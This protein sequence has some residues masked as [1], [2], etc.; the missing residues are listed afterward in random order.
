MKRIIIESPY[1]GDV[2]ANTSYARKCLRDALA[3]DEAPLASHLLYTQVLND[4]VPAERNLGLNAAMEWRDMAEQTVFYTDLGWSP[5]MLSALQA[6]LFE[7]NLDFIFRSLNG[8]PQLPH[9]TP[10]AKLAQ[11]L[12][13]HVEKPRDQT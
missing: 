8:Q 6:M 9:D 11:L 3:R 4:T 13:Q 10:D 1:A 12:A 2:D 5:G 7:G